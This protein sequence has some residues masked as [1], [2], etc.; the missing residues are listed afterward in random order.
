M[1]QRK[2][3]P[4]QVI[5]HFA[6]WFPLAWLV[7]DFWLGN[8]GPEPIRAAILRTGKAALL[9]LILSLA[10]TPLNILFGFKP[11]LK[12]RR[13]LG[14][15][16]FMYASLHFSLFVG[17]DYFF[18][19]ALIKD[20]LFEKRYALVGLAAGLILLLLAITSTDGWKRRLR[21]NWK[22]LHK[23]TYAAGILAII[24]FVWSVKQGVLEPWIWGIVMASL[25]LFRLKAVKKWASLRAKAL[26]TP[27]D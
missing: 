23:L 22:R 4:L 7:W 13:P 14:L 8:L 3:T 6:S 18:D 27:S 9:W 10:C 15:Y 19:F 2:I 5:V 21:S 16:S 25:L 11:V 24:H 17:I 1:K 26:F 12:L 20:A